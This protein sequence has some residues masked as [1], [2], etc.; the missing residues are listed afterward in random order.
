MSNESY[1]SNEINFK[2]TT[3]NN[4][5]FLNFLLEVGKVTGGRGQKE[6][7]D[8]LW[9]TGCYLTSWSMKKSIEDHSN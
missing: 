2:M 1:Q 5:T 4:K 9:K 8:K 3:M 7:L 6:W